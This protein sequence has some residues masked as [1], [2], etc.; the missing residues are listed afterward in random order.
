M[1]GVAF[2][3]PDAEAVVVVEGLAGGEL[4]LAAFAAWLKKN[5]VKSRRRRSVG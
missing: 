5:S 1:N 2:S 3:P 4:T